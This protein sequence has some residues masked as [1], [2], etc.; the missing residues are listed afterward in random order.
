MNELGCWVG[1]G[2]RRVLLLPGDA[3]H[4]GGEDK[5]RVGR[6]AGLLAH[7][8]SKVNPS[9]WSPEG[10]SCQSPHGDFELGPSRLHFQKVNII[11]TLSPLFFLFVFKYLF[12]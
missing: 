2:E 6:G 4:S 1:G 7:G 12:I 11:S 5:A 10:S 8:G 3:S 9:Q